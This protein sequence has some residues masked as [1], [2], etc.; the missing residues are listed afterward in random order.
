[1]NVKLNCKDE[2]M[3]EALKSVAERHN[4]N[5]K[6]CIFGEKIGD[7]KDEKGTVI[8]LVK[9]Q[10]TYGIWYQLR[11][12]NST[13]SFNCWDTS[14]AGVI[15]TH[16]TCKDDYEYIIGKTFIGWLMKSHD[17]SCR[18]LYVNMAFKVYKKYFN[19]YFNI[20]NDWTGE[21]NNNS[22]RTIIAI[23][24][25]TRF[26]ESFFEKCWEF[27]ARGFVV[28]LPNFRPSNMMS[29]GFDIPEE[30]LED[31]GFKR[32]DMADKVYVVNENGYIGESTAKEIDYAKSLGKNIRYMEEV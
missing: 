20:T 17:E 6:C 28:T 30:I 22:H 19:K 26:K 31:I 18:S 9:E 13:K 24:G 3:K 14:V 4:K 12:F 23:I 29:K 27:S 1:M 11:L 2:A 32:I 8:S 5:Q 21:E 25:S 15:S 10:E 7:W 16:G